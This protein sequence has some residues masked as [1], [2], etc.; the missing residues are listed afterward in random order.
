MAGRAENVGPEWCVTIERGKVREFARAVRDPQAE[1]NVD[2]VPPTFP[3]YLSA[4]VL[5]GLLVCNE[6]GL[7][8]RRLLHG[9]QEYEYLRP[10]RVGDR[11]RC[12]MRLVGDYVKEGRRGGSMRFVVLET[13]F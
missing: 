11:L 9:E 8:R 6:L 5:D 7:D 12:R 10:L 4:D 3:V 2:S 13:E 1:A